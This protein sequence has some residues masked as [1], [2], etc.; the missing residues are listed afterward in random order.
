MNTEPKTYTAKVAMENG[1]IVL[2]FDPTMLEDLGW[3][4][5]T[6]IVWE[7]RDDAVIVRKI[8]D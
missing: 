8:D 6:N 5:G 1:E 4:E 7:I 2:V 3:T